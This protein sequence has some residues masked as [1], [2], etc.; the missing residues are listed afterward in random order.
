MIV[1]AGATGTTGRPI[2]EALCRAGQPVRALAR[3]RDKLEIARRLGAEP[4]QVDLTDSVGLARCFR[5]ADAVYTLIPPSFAAPDFPAYQRQVASAVS[6]AV[7]RSEVQRVVLLSSL[8]AHLPSGGGVVQGLHELEEKLFELGIAVLSLRP[9]CF[10]E[11][12]VAML[13]MVRQTGALGSLV[14][15]AVRFPLLAAR[16]VSQHA[17]ARLLERD[18]RGNAVQYLL[19][20]ADTCFDEIAGVLGRSF[21]KPDLAYVEMPRE[22][23]REVMRRGWGVSPSVADAFIETM[24]ALNAGRLTED[25]RRDRKSTTPTTLEQFLPQLERAWRARPA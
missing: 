10:M 19:G 1:V 6:D 14:R 22:R 16:D 2:V 4:H 12:L 9:G 23:A 5:G 20:P 21:G 7:R 24:E 11:N 25:A 18:W 8:G 3:G 15:G 17:A 13:P